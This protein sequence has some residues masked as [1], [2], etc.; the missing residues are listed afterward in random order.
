[1]FVYIQ[2]IVVVWG[3]SHSGPAANLLG[4]CAA[5][6]EPTH[7]YQFEFLPQVFVI[8]IKCDLSREYKVFSLHTSEAKVGDKNMLRSVAATPCFMLR[9]RGDGGYK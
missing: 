8:S 6:C 9:E 2:I 5:L 3:T 4:I 1:M 7:F